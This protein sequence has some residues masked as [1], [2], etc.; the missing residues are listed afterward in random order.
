V[1]T[2]WVFDRTEKVL[3]SEIFDSIVLQEE[4]GKERK[5][6]RKIRKVEVK[7]RQNAI[8]LFILRDPTRREG[9]R[10]LSDFFTPRAISL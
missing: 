1:R 7:L 6:E 10:G 4:K 2:P 9:G 8:D 3:A 5:E